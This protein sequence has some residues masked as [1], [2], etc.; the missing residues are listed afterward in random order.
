MLA[1]SRRATVE[2]AM[3]HSIVAIIKVRDGRRAELA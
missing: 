3:T 2:Y 1:A